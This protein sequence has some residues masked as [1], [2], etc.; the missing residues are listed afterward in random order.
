M[1]TALAV[2]ALL[3]FFLSPAEAAANEAP[4]SGGDE[5]STHEGGG[6][7]DPLQQ[8]EDWIAVAGIVCYSVVPVVLI[9]GASILAY[10]FFTRESSGALLGPWER[11]AWIW[12]GAR[13]PG[14]RPPP[15]GLVLWR[16]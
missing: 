2:L 3:F 15:G 9:V 8:R 13:G 16:F 6:E 7:R 5:R 1:R 10:R 12:R 14:A 11:G 4:G